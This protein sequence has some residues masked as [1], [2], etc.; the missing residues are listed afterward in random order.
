[1]PL[2]ALLF[3]CASPGTD[4]AGGGGQCNLAQHD[5]NEPV[6]R[7]EFDAL[8]KAYIDE[9]PEMVTEMTQKLRVKQVAERQAKSKQAL[10]E[11]R[12]AVF[13]DSNDPVLG[14]PM[15]DVTLVEFFDDECPFCKKLSPTLDEL[16]S[17]DSG[18][19]VVLKEYPILGPGSEVAARYALAAIRQ[20]KYAEFHSALMNDKTPERQLAE[21]HILEIA[22]SVGLD[23]GRLKKDAGA[24][25]ISGRIENNR[26]LARKLSISGTPGLVIGGRI[27]S[28]ALSLEALQQAVSDER[29]ARQ[30]AG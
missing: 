18:V 9:H 29:R 3:G 21:P 13:E 20:G 12:S 28:G 4:C 19:R 25:E 26:T 22:T 14:N 23:V 10:A 8:L 27:E 11:N 2:L 1:M 15:G 5:A 30:P 6:R 17:K 16:V 24:P 7:G